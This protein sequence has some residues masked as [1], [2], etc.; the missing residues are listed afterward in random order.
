MYV[1]WEPKDEQGKTIY[2]QVESQHDYLFY[3]KDVVRYTL[4]IDI[5]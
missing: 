3:Y 5:D 4:F 1:V 2:G